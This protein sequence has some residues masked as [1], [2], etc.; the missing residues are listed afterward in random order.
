MEPAL[1][2]QQ[3]RDP[4]SYGQIM[5]PDHRPVLDLQRRA[6]APP[7]TPGLERELDLEFELLA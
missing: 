6:S 3:P 1:A 5:D 7:A 2:P 4:A